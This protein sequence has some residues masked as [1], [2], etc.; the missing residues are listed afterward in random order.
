MASS[1]LFSRLMEEY[2]SQ[3]QEKETDTEKPEGSEGKVSTDDKKTE[4]KVPALMQQEERNTGAV[5]WTTYK[6]YL[7]FAGG[8][9]W[10]PFILLLLILGQVSQGRSYGF[11][12]RFQWC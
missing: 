3:E 7:Q 2:G 12:H 10:G 4:K 1:V 11:D 9:T 6:K 5:S 8:V